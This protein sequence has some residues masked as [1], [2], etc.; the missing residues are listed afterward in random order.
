MDSN[1]D[2]LPHVVFACVVLHNFGELRQSLVEENA[3]EARPHDSLTRPPT[4]LAP[5]RTA[6]ETEGRRVLTK[7]LD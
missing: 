1:I 2:D 7:L 3:S 6:D 4:N 5:G